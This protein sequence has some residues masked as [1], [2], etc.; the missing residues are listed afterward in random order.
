MSEPTTQA[1]QPKGRKILGMSQGQLLI[2]L[3]VALVGGAYLLWRRNKSKQAQQQAAS[4]CPD[5]SAPDANG[6]CVQSGQDWSGAIATLQTEIA[7]LQG[8]SAGA[9]GAAGATSGSAGSTEGGGFGTP[10]GG[11]ST[12]LAPSPASTGGQASGYHAAGAIS[13]LQQ[14][15]RTSR[16][17]SIR[18]NPALNTRL[19]YRYVLSSIPAGHPTARA[20]HA[21]QPV[22]SG[23]TTATSVRLTGLKPRT[24]YNFGIQ[25]LPGGPGN[26]I[27]VST[28]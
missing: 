9:G 25:A 4:A 12:T 18:W 14:T 22:K 11:T 7:D 19:G 3:G 2:V 27:H 6:A 10:G 1:A 20:P 5:G 26:N 23:Q 21:G 24:T 16:S 8:A 15:G 17:I 28:S 13:N